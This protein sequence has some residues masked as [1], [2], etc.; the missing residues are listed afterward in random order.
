MQFGQFDG[1]DVSQHSFVYYRDQVHMFLAQYL[2]FMFRA[3]LVQ[4]QQKKVAKRA[5][6]TAA[7]SRTKEE[8]RQKRK[9]RRSESSPP[10]ADRQQDGGLVTDLQSAPSQHPGTDD[11]PHELIIED[12]GIDADAVDMFKD[13]FN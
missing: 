4:A 12:N 9:R 7:R 2:P 1:L 3:M 6:E 8:K 11:H 5:K 10:T 13:M